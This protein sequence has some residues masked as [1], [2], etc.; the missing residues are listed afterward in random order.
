MLPAA[1]LL[2]ACGSSD[3]SSPGSIVETP[4]DD[5][6][7][8][9]VDVAASNLTQ[10][11]QAFE[12]P[13]HIAPTQRWTM[14]TNGLCGNECRNGPRHMYSAA[15]GDTLLVSW[16]A[17]DEDDPW[18]QYGNVAT[19]QQGSDGRFTLTNNVA[20]DGL[21][22]ATYG[23]TTN[24]DGSV[25]A[26]L[27]RGI[28]G[29]TTPYAGAINLLDGRRTAGCTEDWEGRCYPIGNYSANDS[30]LYLLEFRGGSVDATPDS[31]V[32]I[33]HAVGGWRYGH[34]ELA[35]NANEDTYVVHLKVTAGPTVD[36][37]HEGM[38]R[39]AIRRTPEFAYVPID[40]EWSCGGGHVTTNRMAY[41]RATDR[42]AQVC[43]LDACPLP[44]QYVNGRCDSISF[45][46]IANASQ[47]SPPERLD[48]EGAASLL[49]MQVVE[50]DAGGRNEWEKTGGVT[51]LLSL[52]ADG[53]LALAAGPGYPG[54]Q[55]KPDTIGTIRL[56][57][58][59]A[60]LAPRAQT[61][62]VPQF[63]GGAQVGQQDATRYQWN[64][65]F[66]PASQRTAPWRVGMANMAY[67]GTEGEAS[68]R[69]LAGWSPTI[70][71]Q[72]ITSEYVV[73]EIDRD[74]NLR[75][76]P[77]RLS[78]AGWGED[79]RW[80][81]MPRSGCVVFPFAWVGAAPGENYPAEAEGRVA[82]DYPTTL[83]VT[84]VCPLGAQ[85]AP[86]TVPAPVPDAERWPAP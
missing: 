22:E 80:E 59:L 41:N 37:R 52:G 35:L 42:W 17:V 8:T 16:M 10:V 9:E 24:A 18:R 4:S 2:A 46:T 84:A 44:S 75:G 71:F 60:E 55:S 79:N 67:F 81:T 57:L 39:V 83:R 47:A 6:G 54:A 77:F 38:T 25:I 86:A 45:S 53:W 85:P 29:Q 32:Y 68:E 49:E 27:C 82:S 34:H 7:T 40:D 69:L 76:E 5:P 65:L 70:A 15:F 20:F 23:I 50:K 43:Q 63:E 58:T 26:V 72:G 74:G 56:P 66:L 14:R 73:S 21:C 28:T 3:T 78:N 12:L 62:S 33:N 1:L 30:A 36:N 31:I 64:W 13:G 48:Y 51:S 61:V 11:T 19:F